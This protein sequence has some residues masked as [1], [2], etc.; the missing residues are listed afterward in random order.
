M[1]YQKGAYA[2]GYSVS[3]R[4]RSPEGAIYFAGEQ[5]SGLTGWQE[6][7]VLAT[8]AVL[9]AINDRVAAERS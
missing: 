4:L 8:Y 7:A 2:L 5:I 9:E 3:E 1:P 6:G